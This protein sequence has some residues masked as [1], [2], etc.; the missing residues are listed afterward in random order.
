MVLSCDAFHEGSC[1]DAPNISHKKNHKDTLL[2][3]TGQQS[4][5]YQIF[6]LAKHQSYTATSNFA[7]GKKLNIF[8]F[9]SPNI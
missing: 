8:A 9:N 2:Y 3:E 4:C 5:F 7:V 1:V 6:F